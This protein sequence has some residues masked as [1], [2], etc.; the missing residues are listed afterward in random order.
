M[1]T[2]INRHGITTIVSPQR[3]QY[4]IAHDGARLADEAALQGAPAPVV[5]PKESAKPVA[6]VE[7]F[8]PPAE[9]APLPKKTRKTT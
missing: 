6:P 9:P 3:A 5:E 2:I 8:A 1:P 4:M 7:A